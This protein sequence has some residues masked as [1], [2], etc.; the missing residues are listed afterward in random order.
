MRGV[1][2]A[3]FHGNSLSLDVYESAYTPAAMIFA[4]KHGQLFKEVPK[5]ETPVAQSTDFNILPVV[6]AQQLSLFG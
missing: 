2:A 5:E 3:V 6:N 4:G 1:P